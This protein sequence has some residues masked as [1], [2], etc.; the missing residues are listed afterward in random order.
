[1]VFF[2][3][4]DN[5]GDFTLLFP[6]HRCN[7]SP[8]TTGAKRGSGAPV[9]AVLML[10][11]NGMRREEDLQGWIKYFSA[12]KTCQEVTKPLPH[13]WGPSGMTSAKDGSRGTQ[14]VLPG[15]EVTGGK[16]SSGTRA[17]D[18]SEVMQ[19]VHA[20]S[21]R[22]A[23]TSHL[24]PFT[25]ISLFSSDVKRCLDRWLQHDNPCKSPLDFISYLAFKP[26]WITY[27][28]LSG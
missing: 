27:Q 28:Q 20:G 9:P 13:T 16:L 4:P 18:F 12:P 15:C 19:Q 21:E 17:S 7:S 24:L 5:T 8:C 14:A 25:V 1:M 3:C 22:E 11:A 10:T 26:A 2:L 23:R 6:C